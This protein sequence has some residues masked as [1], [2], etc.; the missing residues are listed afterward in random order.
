MINQPLQ[1]AEWSEIRTNK[2]NELLTLSQDRAVLLV[3]LR[4]LGCMFCREAMTELG[5]LRP[6]LE[7]S[8][9]QIVFVHM[10]PADIAEKLFKR[11]K[12]AGCEHITDPDCY[13]Y[14]RFG[15]VKG[16]MSQLFGLTSWV[17]TLDFG[18]VKGHGYTLPIG[19]GFQMPGLFMVQHGKV[20]AEFRHTEVYDQP[21]YAAFA[22]CCA[23]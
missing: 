9:T 7:A 1:L 11:Y 8:G 2:G 4:Q 18:I 13:Y 17:K 15:L 19:D 6:S 22:A 23:V 3:F 14:A 16:S 5:K 20:V 12:L 10:G 21:D